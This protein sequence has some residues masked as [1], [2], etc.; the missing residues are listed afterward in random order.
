MSYD[1]GEATKGLENEAELHLRHSSLSNPSIASP[2]SQFIPQPY[3]VDEN[4]WDIDRKRNHEKE[5]MQAG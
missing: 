3:V 4:T 5:K 1:I 2:T